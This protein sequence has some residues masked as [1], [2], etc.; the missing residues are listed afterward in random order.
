ML[1]WA[2]RRD[3]LIHPLHREALSHHSNGV[4]L[5][6][7]SRRDLVLDKQIEMVTILLSLKTTLTGANCAASRVMLG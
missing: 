4:H 6:V 7:F 1:F 2:E 3:E 5:E